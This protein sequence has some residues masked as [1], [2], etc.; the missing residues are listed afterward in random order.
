MNTS[1]SAA[2]AA[3]DLV[4]A[5]APGDEIEVTSAMLD[6]AEPVFTE[7]FMV[8]R[9]GDP[10]AIRSMLTEIYR[11]MVAASRSSQNSTAKDA[12]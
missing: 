1:C 4:G 9:Y 8:I 6:A 10:T 7:Y 2:D 3:T 5:G 12:A 11:R